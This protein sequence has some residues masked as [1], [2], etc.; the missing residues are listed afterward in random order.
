MRT[1]PVDYEGSYFGGQPQLQ[2]A[3]NSVGKKGYQPTYP[4]IDHPE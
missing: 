4:C 1:K 2:P 3:Y